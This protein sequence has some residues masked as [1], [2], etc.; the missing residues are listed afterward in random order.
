M[1][2]ACKREREI[3]KLLISSGLV[4]RTSRA[5]ESPVDIIFAGPSDH[6]F[7]DDDDDDG[8]ILFVIVRL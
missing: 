8:F 5:S 7:N 1:R 2:Y 3:L 6:S 4:E